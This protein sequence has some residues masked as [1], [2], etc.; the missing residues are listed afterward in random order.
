LAA[1]GEGILEVHAGNPKAA[2]S[3]LQEA[4][5]YE[6]SET[7][8]VS[9][10]W[11]MYP[12]YVRGQ[13]YLLAHDGRAA[14]AEFKKMLDHRGIV[15]NSILGALSRLEFARAEVMVG[16]VEDGRKQYSDFLSLWKDAD[17]DIPVLKEAEAEYAKLQ[18]SPTLKP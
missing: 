1:D 5:P 9:N 7:S 4:A 15:Q 8:N 18:S 12:V 16:D 6:F 3:F 11:N 10:A 17:P 14:A 13:A 2:I